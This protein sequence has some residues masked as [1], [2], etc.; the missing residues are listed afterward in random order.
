M[1]SL[2]AASYSLVEEGGTSMDVCAQINNVLSPTGTPAGISVTLLL[3]SGTA[4]MSSKMPSVAMHMYTRVL[5]FIT[6]CMT[7]LLHYAT[8]YHASVTRLILIW[9]VATVYVKCLFYII[10]FFVSAVGADIALSS[11]SNGVLMFNA[12]S[13]DGQEVCAT[14]NII[15]DNVLEGDEQ[16]QVSL[17]SPT[18]GANLEDPSTAFATILDNDSMTV[19]AV[20][21]L[22]RPMRTSQDTV[23]IP[24]RQ[25]CVQNSP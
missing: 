9:P 20:E 14:L 13:M 19:N 25:S 23:W 7:L 5:C 12:G 17:S 22:Y 2:S 3:T 24:A 16:F 18:G 15:D 8:H 6:T 21:P 11:P 1:I 4:S 10:H